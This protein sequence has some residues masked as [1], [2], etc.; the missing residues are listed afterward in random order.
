MPLRPHFLE[1]ARNP[2][3]RGRNDEGIELQKRLPMEVD[4][5]FAQIKHVSL[6]L[7]SNSDVQLY[8]CH[9]DELLSETSTH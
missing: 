9:T 6:T 4:T 3:L 8:I 7:F 5:P 2:W 1:W